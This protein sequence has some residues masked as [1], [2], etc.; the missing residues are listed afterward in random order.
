MIRH[1]QICKKN[2]RR[3][4]KLL[5][6]LIGCPTGRIERKLSGTEQGIDKVDCNW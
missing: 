4:R 5:I 3:V 2:G 6:D 1:R